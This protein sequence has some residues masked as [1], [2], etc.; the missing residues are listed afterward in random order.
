MTGKV[1]LRTIAAV[2]DFLV[3]EG[4]TI[5]EMMAATGYARSSI[6]SALAHL[7]SRGAPEVRNQRRD[8]PGGRPRVIV[9]KPIVFID[10]AIVVQRAIASRTPLERAWGM[11]A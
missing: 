11:A 8:R 2:S 10:P 4:G 9:E 3:K 1:G 5:T 7:R 6:E